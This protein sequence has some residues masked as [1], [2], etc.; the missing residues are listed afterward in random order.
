MLAEA[1]AGSEGDFVARMNAT[2]KRL[3]MTRTNFV[4][5]NGLPADDQV[6]TARDLAKLSRAV[7]TDFPEYAHYWSMPHMRLGKNRLARTTGF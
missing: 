3:G 1:V 4:N 7:I 6:T 2:A 5:A